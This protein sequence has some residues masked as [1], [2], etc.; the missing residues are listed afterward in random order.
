MPHAPLIVLKFGGSVLLDENRLRMAVHEIYRWRRDGW[1]VIA[2]VSA[3]CGTT[4]AL[5]ARCRRLHDRVSA[6]AHAAVIAG[7]ELECAALLG[8]HLDRAGLP[9]SVIT[10]CAASFLAEGP[11]LDAN[12][13]TIDHRIIDRALTRDGVVVF[14]GFVALDDSGRTVTLGRGGSDLTALYLAYA[15]HAER[16]R[17][18]KDVDGLY[19]NDPARSDPP[20][21]RYECATYDDALATDGSI[22]QHKA[23][24]YAQQHGLM[25]ELARFNG[26]RPTRIGT[27]S[28][29]LSDE[30]DRPIKQT[31]GL[32]G[33]GTVGTGVL[34]LLLQLPEYFHV[35]G[36]AVRTPRRH[37]SAIPAGIPVTTDA[38]ALARSDADII[39]ETIG[40]TDTASEATLAA[41]HRGATVVSAN[42]AVLADLGGQLSAAARAS[43]ASILASAS[44]GG[45]VPVLERVTQQREC[46]AGVRAVL[47]GTSNYVLERIAAGAALDRAI[48]DAQ[49]LGLA[50]ADPSRDL[51][52]RD[53]IDKL[54]I[55]AGALCIDQKCL[56]ITNHGSITSRSLVQN[57]LESGQRL[58]QVAA[59]DR[60]GGISLSLSSVMHDDPLYELP[61]ESNAIEIQYADGTTAVI[62]GKGAGCWPTAE[63][64]IADLLE[65]SRRR[66][67][68]IQTRNKSKEVCHA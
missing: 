2:V 3:L 61:E 34:D 26:T 10:P 48:A 43:G 21:Q 65:L 19:E 31:V 12:P 4:D 7:G 35:T 28:S 64:V 22:I 30:Y 40:G 59:I 62:R 66:C 24:R 15:L 32:L 60:A 25:F 63:S 38:I 37:T 52:G 55:I 57:K 50:E 51:D 23:V 53:S 67:E 18:I 49:R 44:V 8:L 11:P 29:R 6:H 56:R 1:R 20:P 27:T 36:I 13:R 45:G 68:C 47:N 46:I 58:R 54:R 9:A 33:H 5:I 39:V 42:K 14:P 41:L 16:C 17:L